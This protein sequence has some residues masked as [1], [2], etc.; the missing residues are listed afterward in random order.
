MALSLL[1]PLTRNDASGKLRCCV[2]EINQQI[3]IAVMKMVSHLISLAASEVL[4]V[5]RQARGA[6]ERRLSHKP[7][8]YS[9]AAD[10]ALMV[11]QGDTVFLEERGQV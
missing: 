10:D 2:A 8:C 11:D 5:F 4:D 3:Y 1:R 7:F 9:C 6:E